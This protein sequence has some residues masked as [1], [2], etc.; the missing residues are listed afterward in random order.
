[1][2]VLHPAAYLKLVSQLVKSLG[3]SA[4]EDWQVVAI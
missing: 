1:M 4:Q 3:F 2:L